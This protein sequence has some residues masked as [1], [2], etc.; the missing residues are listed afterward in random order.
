MWP[1]SRVQLPAFEGP[2]LLGPSTLAKEALAI[3][4]GELGRGETEINNDGP[5]II[6]YRRGKRDFQPWC[7]ALVS[8]CFEEAAQR[9]GA[10]LPFERSHSA[11]RLWKRIAAAGEKSETPMPGD[12]VL[13]HRGRAGASTGHIGIVSRVD[14][15]SF[16]SIE[17]NRGR[18]PSKVREYQHE[19][20]EALLLGFARV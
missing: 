11:K 8:Y 19:L 1:F 16:F 2:R 6:I 20:G 10:K 3:A 13:W 12:C 7:A 17:G 5:D 18:P 9:I 4:R 15:N 14:G